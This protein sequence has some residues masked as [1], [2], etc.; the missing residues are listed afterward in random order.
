MPMKLRSTGTDFFFAG[1]H[2]H[3]F[4]SALLEKPKQDRVAVLVA[5]AFLGWLM[6]RPKVL[7]LLTVQRH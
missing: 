6:L 3:L 5:A 1:L 4:N 2:K 7:N